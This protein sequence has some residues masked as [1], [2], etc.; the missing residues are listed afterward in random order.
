MLWLSFMVAFAAGAVTFE[1][2]L[3]LF[4]DT[5]SKHCI[6]GWTCLVLGTFF[7]LIHLHNGRDELVLLT[8]WACG[9]VSVFAFGIPKRWMYRG[10]HS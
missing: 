6:T 4:W 7:F 1:L 2:L 9:L 8:G 10:R 5:L 3:I